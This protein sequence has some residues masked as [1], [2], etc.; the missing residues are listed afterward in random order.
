MMKDNDLVQPIIT[1]RF[2]ITCDTKLMTCLTKI[3]QNHDLS[4]QSH[5]NE[6]LS[7]I[8]F[9]RQLF[10]NALNYADVYKQHG[11]LTKKTIMAHC[12]HMENQEIDIFSETGTSVAHCPTS[13]NNLSSG[14][15]DVQRIRDHNVEVGLGTDVSGGNKVG[16]FDVMRKALDVSQSLYFMKTQDV[17][18]VGKMP[19]NES[20][21]TYKPLNYKNVLYLATLGGARALSLHDK[22]GDFVTGKD[23]DALIIDVSKE[24]IVD[25]ELPSESSEKNLLNKIQKFVYVGDD[26]NILNVFVKGHLLK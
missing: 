15:C 2:A 25:Y 5:I 17:K 12:V 21:S 26:R 6:N 9:V 14:L 23:F 1:P 19:L 13:N 24:P 20:N 22:I 4:I 8:D 10:P 3:A 16:I 18:G 7:E 11:L